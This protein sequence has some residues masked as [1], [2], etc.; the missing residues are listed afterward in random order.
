[1]QIDV[2]AQI[3]T[4]KRL[5]RE[6]AERAGYKQPLEEPAVEMSKRAR[7]CQRVLAASSFGCQDRNVHLLIEAVI[8]EKIQMPKRRE[9]VDYLSR[10]RFAIGSVLVPANSYDMRATRAGLV[11]RVSGS[12]NAGL[13][14]SSGEMHT[15]HYQ[16]HDLRPATDEEIDAYYSEFF[17]LSV[18]PA[19]VAD[20]PIHELAAEEAF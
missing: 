10:E 7:D 5:T 9:M 18:N 12:G 14:M 6:W 13:R 4:A 8:G 16:Q 19:D 3:E 1:M 11:V 17:G 20:E 15:N 2:S